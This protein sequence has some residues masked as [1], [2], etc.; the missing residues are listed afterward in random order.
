MA[1]SMLENYIEKTTKGS[2]S[3]SENTFHY[4]LFSILE[5]IRV[6]FQNKPELFG[7]NEE[8]H[9]IISWDL[10]G[11]RIE[12][13]HRKKL[14]EKVLPVVF[15]HSKLASFFRQVIYSL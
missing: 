4:K 9:D 10:E 7:K 12:I 3:P 15:S 6:S 13:K 11:L 8:Y 14:E 1:Q 5:V 2:E